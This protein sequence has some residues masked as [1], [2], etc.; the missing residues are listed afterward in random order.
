M[1]F[2]VERAKCQIAIAISMDLLERAGKT[3]LNLTA[4]FPM[5]GEA[6]SH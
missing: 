3:T 4:L 2:E 1:V 5:S 6:I